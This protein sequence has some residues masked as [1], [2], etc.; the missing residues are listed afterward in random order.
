[1]RNEL[2]TVG[3]LVLTNEVIGYKVPVS[4]LGNNR[5]TARRS[6]TTGRVTG[7]TGYPGEISW[8]VTHHLD[9]SQA[10]YS[11]NEFELDE[12]ASELIQPDPSLF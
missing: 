5:V 4:L 8:V 9:K 2:V 6:N 11:S 12:L 3:L 7:M 10:L 1:M